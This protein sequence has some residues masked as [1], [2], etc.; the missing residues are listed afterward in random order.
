M[1]YKLIEKVKSY[2]RHV[3]LILVEIHSG[4]IAEVL[5]DCLASQETLRANL[6]SLSDIHPSHSL[7]LG[8]VPCQLDLAR[9][10]KDM[11]NGR[12]LLPLRR[13]LAQI[14]PNTI[15]TLR[16]DE[17]LRCHLNSSIRGPP[18]IEDVVVSLISH[19]WFVVLIDEDEAADGEFRVEALGVQVAP[20]VLEI[21]LGAG[22]KVEL[23]IGQDL[24]PA[25]SMLNHSLMQITNNT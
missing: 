2:Q 23:V 22:V 6:P 25:S 12:S 3:H 7:E 20:F 4:S 10:I 21:D 17:I 5:D 13:Y 1:V 8:N 19:G 16:I 18:I 11:H 14:N 9:H 24:A 15:N